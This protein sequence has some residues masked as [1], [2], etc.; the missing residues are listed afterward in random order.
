MNLEDT[1]TYV[2]VGFLSPRLLWWCSST[3]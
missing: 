3:R 2:S 1:H